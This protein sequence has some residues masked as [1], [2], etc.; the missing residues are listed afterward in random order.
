MPRWNLCSTCYICITVIYK[1]LKLSS[2]GFHQMYMT[3]DD[4]NWHRNIFYQTLFQSNKKSNRM[5]F[6]NTRHTFGIKLLP[7]IYLMKLTILNTVKTLWNIPIITEC[8][9]DEHLVTWDEK[10]W[11]ANL[12]DQQQWR[13]HFFPWYTQKLVENILE[14]RTAWQIN[15]WVQNCSCHRIV[16]NSSETFRRNPNCVRNIKDTP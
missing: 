14:K 4:I 3:S 2:I 12:I 11:S 9:Q 1:I 6:E 16:Y 15:I 8:C 5:T 7:N 13:Q 10:L